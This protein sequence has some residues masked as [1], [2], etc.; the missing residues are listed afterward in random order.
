MAAR[1]EAGRV[2]RSTKHFR[3]DLAQDLEAVIQPSIR[4]PAVV[5]LELLSDDKEHFT[6]LAEAV[7]DRAHLGPSDRDHEPI[8]S[9]VDISPQ[10]PAP[11]PVAARPHLVGE[12][13]VSE[14]SPG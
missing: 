10:L 4:P 14:V 8:E 9:R 3:L 12:S 11:R 5:A 13:L 6:Q 7:R 2:L 1:A